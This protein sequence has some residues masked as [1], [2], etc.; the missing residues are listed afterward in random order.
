MFPIVWKIIYCSHQQ[1]FMTWPFFY[2]FFNQNILSIF[3]FTIF[4]FYT[5]LSYVFLLISTI[6]IQYIPQKFQDFFISSFIS[7]Y[8]LNTLVAE[9]NLSWLIYELI[10]TLDIRTLIVF[11]FVFTNSTILLCLLF[12]FLDNRLILAVIVQIF[13]P[14][15]ELVIQIGMPT[16]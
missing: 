7:L 11:N 12:F 4:C 16:H 13:I 6:F 1:M 3:C 9:T 5:I 15:A 2:M 8:L 14:T 10:K